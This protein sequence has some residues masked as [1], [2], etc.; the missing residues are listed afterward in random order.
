MNSSFRPIVGITLGDPI[1][2]GSEIILK[3][4]ANV[5]IY[6]KCRPLVIGSSEPLRK[7]LSTLKMDLRLNVI[8]T[9]EKGSYSHGSIDVIDCGV[10][11]GNLTMGKV[12]KEAGEASVTYIKRAI[13][14]LL[15]KTIDATA[16]GPNNKEAIRLAGYN[17]P[18]VTEMFADWTNAPKPVSTLLIVGPLRIFQITTH[19][20][21]RQAIEMLTF[22]RILDAIVN[23]D[24]V[25]TQLEGKKPRLAIA[26]LNPHA[27]ENGLM[28]REE[29][30]IIRPAIEAAQQ[31]GIDIEGP[32]PAD[33]I[34][35]NGL[36]NEFTG[37]L[38]LFH[39]Q[40]NIGIKLLAEKYPPVT[41]A[42]GLPVIRTTV[43]HGTAYDIAFKGIANHMPMYKAIEVAAELAKAR[44]EESINK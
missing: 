7:A 43:A 9:P 12:H 4:L 41:V 24:Q 13:E 22:E 15:N 23:A 37:L 38:F 11:V 20:S 40:A 10:P 29:I 8:E 3:S 26:G 34:L 30:E 42:A 25:L 44:H 5:E 16:S 36:R 17:Y 6:E 33:S 1:G 28:G 27:G 2:I 39:D 14:M 31:M 18:G 19:V 21:M 32:L 35:I